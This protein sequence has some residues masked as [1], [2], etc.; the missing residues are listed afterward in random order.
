M[1]SIQNLFSLLVMIVH[2]QSATYNSMNYRARDCAVQTGNNR[3]L[4]L[5]FNIRLEPKCYTIGN[6]FRGERNLRSRVLN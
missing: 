3:P 4:S 1:A 6:G 5:D 2:Y